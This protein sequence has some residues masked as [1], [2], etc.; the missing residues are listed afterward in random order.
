MT[1]RRS[2]R[3]ATL[4]MCLA[5][6]GSACSANQ[7]APPPKAETAAAPKVVT[8]EER[9]KWYQDCW[10]DF[11]E[12]K[13]DDF[14][15]CYAPTATSVQAGYGKEKATGPD[16]I[17]GS[18]QDF[19]KSF[20][21]GKGEGQL[22]LING[23]HIASIYLLKGTNSGPMTVGGKELPATNKKF[24]LL[25]GHAIETDPEGRIVI[26]EIGVMDGGTLAA[27]LGLA[28][29]PARPV[30]NKG[31]DMPKVVIARNDATEM[32]NLAADKA[33][34]DGWNKHDA[35]TVA[36]Y[37]ADDVVFHS[38]ADPKD[39]NKKEGAQEDKSFWTAFSDA[40][41]NADPMWAAGDYVVVTGTFEGTNDG[42][43]PAMHISKTGKKVSVPFVEV[44]RFDNGKVKESW[45]FF[46]NNS[47][48]GQLK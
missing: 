15:K 22:I 43:F 30:M 19:T 41:V 38:M 5:V 42:D 37:T 47:F 36:M 8:P 46:D 32:M 34:V 1:R 31:E 4:L 39:V 7:P 9:V 44:D 18:S 10:N 33:G 24:G 28:K 29:M 26:K 11:N 48:M 25:F 17:V 16:A 21:D 13:W 27:Q 23:N 45:L 12:K 35:T 40:R 14:K 2:A 20:P 6:L 3:P